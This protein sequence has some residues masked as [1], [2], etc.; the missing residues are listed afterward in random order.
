MVSKLQCGKSAG[1]DG[2]NVE[3]FH[4]STVNYSCYC[5]YYNYNSDTIMCV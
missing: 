5:H 2:I 3:C 1:P 4:F